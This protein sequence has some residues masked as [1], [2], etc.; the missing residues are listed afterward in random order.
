M[1]T[2]NNYCKYP[3]FYQASQWVSVE[4]ADGQRQWFGIKVEESKGLI[5]DA[6]WFVSSP[7]E[8]QAKRF[9]EEMDALLGTS[10]LL[11]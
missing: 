9:N 2:L 4:N 7:N 10:I 1:T 5:L 3:E 6:K 8:E 11:N